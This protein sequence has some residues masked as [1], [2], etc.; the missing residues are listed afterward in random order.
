MSLGVVVFW[1]CTCC[2]HWSFGFD[3]LLF[4]VCWVTYISFAVCFVILIGL[5]ETE[6]YICLL[7]LELVLLGFCSAYGSVWLVVLSGR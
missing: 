5:F 4:V 7:G 6:V 3:L 1:V 2:G